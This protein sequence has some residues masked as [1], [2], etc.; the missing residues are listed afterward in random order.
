[1][2]RLEQQY[3]DIRF[4]W[5]KILREPPPQS[6]PEQEAARRKEQRDAREARRK[7]KK[8]VET[9]EDAETPRRTAAQSEERGFEPTESVPAALI[10]TIDA[11]AAEEEDEIHGPGGENDI[12][13]SEGAPPEGAAP[14]DAGTAPGTPGKRRRRR[15]RRGKRREPGG[16]TPPGGTPPDGTPPT[17]SV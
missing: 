8:P 17:D 14:Q 9:T 13:M 2:A 1:M 3:P 12:V 16:G 6:L 4:D 10:E 11:D 5:D 7:R 15:R